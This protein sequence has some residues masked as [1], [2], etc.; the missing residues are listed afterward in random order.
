M[1]EPRIEMLKYAHDR[2]PRLINKLN[3]T[4]VEK[5]AFAAMLDAQLQ[6]RIQEILHPC[7]YQE[8]VYECTDLF[9]ESSPFCR[10]RAT[11]WTLAKDAKNIRPYFRF[12]ESMESKI[13][14]PF[15]VRMWPRQAQ[16][17][18]RDF[19]KTLVFNNT[20][21]GKIRDI[22]SILPN[23]FVMAAWPQNA[24]DFVESIRREIFKAPTTTPPKHMLEIQK[25]PIM[26][27]GTA[28]RKE[29]NAPYGDE[30]AVKA[31]ANQSPFYQGESAKPEHCRK[32]PLERY[33]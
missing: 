29:D 7:V 6:P 24:R 8:Q 21:Q 5:R 14:D 28:A 13:P 4:M 11:L 18:A 19:Q 22:Q 30:S 20:L 10:S 15:V 25:E 2:L 26:A 27:G 17:F 32:F 16:S 1:F 3:G 9:M 31:F 23:R 33:P 12:L